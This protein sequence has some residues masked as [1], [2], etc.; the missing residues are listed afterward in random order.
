[1]SFGVLWEVSIQKLPSVL[2]TALWLNISPHTVSPPKVVSAYISALWDCWEVIS[3]V[4]ASAGVYCT[5][6]A[7]LCGC[8][9]SLVVGGTKGVVSLLP[10]RL[11]SSPVIW[12]SSK[13]VPHV[14]ILTWLRSRS[15]S[16]SVHRNIFNVLAKDVTGSD[17]K[18]D[19]QCSTQAHTGSQHP[20]RALQHPLGL[21][22]RPLCWENEGLHCGCCWWEESSLCCIH[23]L[24]CWAHC[25][26]HSPCVQCCALLYLCLHPCERHC[27]F[28]WM[29][30]TVHFCYRVQCHADVCCRCLHYTLHCSG[31]SHIACCWKMH[32]PL[33][34]MLLWSP[35][36]SQ[37]GGGSG[38]WV[39]C[40][41]AVRCWHDWSFRRAGS[42]S[43][44]GPW[45]YCLLWG[46]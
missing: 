28:Q 31:C 38:L 17:H 18:E 43:T 22:W 15:E 4:G 10:R 6:A 19:C 21:L 42:P 11:T 9:V 34:G 37:H 46:A 41:M 16:W 5:V 30:Q 27:L 13:A 32:C 39:L 26:Q 1:M 40:C 20:C 45:N 3:L 23:R 8:W 25:W 44:V 2:C 33:S 35:L 24:S 12:G 29:H 36:C 7:S 14:T